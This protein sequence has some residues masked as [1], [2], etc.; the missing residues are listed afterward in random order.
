MLRVCLIFTILSTTTSFCRFKNSFK[1]IILKNYATIK[2]SASIQQFQPTQ[3]FIRN[4]PLDIMEPQLLELL[5][6]VLETKV[7]SVK[8]IRSKVTGFIHVQ[9]S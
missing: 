8:I 1:S 5:N 9:H 4:L 7:I 6:N 3:L 2:C